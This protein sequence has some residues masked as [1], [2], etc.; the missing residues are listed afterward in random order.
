MLQSAI[1]VIN[2]CLFYKVGLYVLG[3]GCTLTFYYRQWTSRSDLKLKRPKEDGRWPQE[4]STDSAITTNK[5]MLQLDRDNLNID[6]P[7]LYFVSKPQTGSRLFN[8]NPLWL[9]GVCATGYVLVFLLSMMPMWQIQL[10]TAFATPQKKE[11]MSRAAY[12]S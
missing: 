4:A 10:G 3:T 8:D 9:V 2:S 6:Q 5:Q 11:E 7:S 12:C 1:K